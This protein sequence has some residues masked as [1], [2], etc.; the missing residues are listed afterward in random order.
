MSRY[1]SSASFFCSMWLG[2]VEKIDFLAVGYFLSS[3]F[4]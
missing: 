3:A 4:L 1:A 2:K